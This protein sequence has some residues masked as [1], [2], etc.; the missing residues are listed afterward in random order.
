VKSRTLR[1]PRSY[2][3]L[4]HG[5]FLTPTRLL[6]LGSSPTA[7]AVA[8]DAVGHGLDAYADPSSSDAVDMLV[9]LAQASPAALIACSGGWLDFVCRC[10]TLLEGYFCCQWRAPNDAL[11]EADSIQ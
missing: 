8:R 3:I 11:P 7:L 6:V 2:T 9:A 1:A 4:L 10:R 5:C